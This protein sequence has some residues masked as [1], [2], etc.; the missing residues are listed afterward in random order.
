[1]DTL[2]DAD[3]DDDAGYTDEPALRSQLMTQVRSTESLAVASLVLSVCSFFAGGFFQLLYFVVSGPGGSPTEQY[4]L[5]SAPTAFFSAI[6]VALGVIVARR[7]T[8]RW[9][10][11][12]GAGVI[13][14]A[15]GIVIT[16]VGAMLVLA[17]GEPL[18]QGF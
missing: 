14:G 17:L 11:L 2:G 13:V 10:G 12:A 5:S 15:L 16:V 1:M 4:L 9:N 6:A 7:P 18:D 3:E 8:D